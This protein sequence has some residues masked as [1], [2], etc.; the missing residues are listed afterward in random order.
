MSFLDRWNWRNDKKAIT[1]LSSLFFGLPEFWE[2][3]VVA[4]NLRVQSNAA[5]GSEVELNRY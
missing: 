1:V 5:E 4:A 3:I 2:E